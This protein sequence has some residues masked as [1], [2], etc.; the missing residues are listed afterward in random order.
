MKPVFIT[1]DAQTHL[2][3]IEL[4]WFTNREKNPDFFRD[5]FERGLD[6]IVKMGDV[7]E[8][9]PRRGVPGLRRRL[10]G[11]GHHIYYVNLPEDIRVLAVWGG[12]RA[13]GPDLGEP[14]F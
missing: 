13:T 4:W 3:E 9:W 5:E 8:P 10:L 1:P 6:L 7:G 2:L 14:P 11:T 12:P